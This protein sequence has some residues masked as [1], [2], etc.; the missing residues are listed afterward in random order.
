MTSDKLACYT[1]L[2]TAFVATIDAPVIVPRE[3]HETKLPPALTPSRRKSRLC[4]WL[5]ISTIVPLVEI[6]TRQRKIYFGS[7]KIPTML[8][9]ISLKIVVKY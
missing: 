9:F 7:I 4:F 2:E 3:A 5:N 8:N 6:I 1:G